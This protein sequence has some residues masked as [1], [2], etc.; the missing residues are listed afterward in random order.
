VIILIAT[1][2]SPPASR[3]LTALPIRFAATA[4]GFTM[5]SVRSIAKPYP[6]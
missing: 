6:L 2:R 5:D 4:S 1:T 3:R